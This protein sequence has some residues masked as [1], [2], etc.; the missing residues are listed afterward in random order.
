[1]EYYYQPTIDKE[2]SA[3]ADR[4]AYAA[5]GEVA[6]RYGS[7]Y[8][9]GVTPDVHDLAYHNLQHSWRVKDAAER[10]ARK[11][12]MTEY[13]IVLVGM[14][15]ASHDVIHE[16]V[17]GQTAEQAS[18][19]WLV[20]R[21][22]A[23]GF[24]E[25]DQTIA[26]LAILGTTMS[27]DADG[28]LGQQFPSIE[29]PGERAGTIALCVAA[30]DM[31]SAYAHYGPSIIH[32]YFKELNGY[33]TFE[34][35]PTLDGL[36]E[37]Q[38][39]QGVFLSNLKSLFV[40]MDQVLGGLKQEGIAHHKQLLDELRAGRITTWAQVIEFDNEFTERHKK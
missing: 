22:Q 12:G 18:A 6:I 27:V 17:D 29:H 24:S 13:D 25:E 36:I 23:E 3:K 16:S 5:L 39:M 21:M 8:D 30:A 37:F 10:V 14:I 26:R 19:E 1:M 40:G 15:A 35:P 20:N 4:L 7:G 28:E 11:L 31:E 34:T 33:G 9:D 38:E 2:Y 32:G